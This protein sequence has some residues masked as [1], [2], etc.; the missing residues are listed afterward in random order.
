M[1]NHIGEKAMK[2]FQLIVLVIA[3]MA[4]HT[5]VRLSRAFES[6]LREI[7]PVFS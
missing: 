2:K 5:L 3:A 4:L 7:C 1:A 6:A